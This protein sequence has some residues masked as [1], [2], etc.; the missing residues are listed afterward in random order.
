MGSVARLEAQKYIS[1]SPSLDGLIRS[2][3]L[4]LDIEVS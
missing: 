1:E 3:K 2:G 4:P